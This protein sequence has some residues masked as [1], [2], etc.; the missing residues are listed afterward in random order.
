MTADHE[1]EPVARWLAGLGLH[2]VVLPYPVAPEG[3][4]G[5]L[6]PAPLDAAAAAVRWVRA[7]G[8]GL[9]VDAG[10]VGVL[11]FS[12]GG[13]L[14]AT[15][16]TVEDAGA[17]PDA[18]VLCYPVVSLVAEPHVGSVD[19]LLGTGADADARAALS[20]DRRV[21]AATP[22]A[23]VW[24]TADDDAVPVSHAVRYAQA[25]WAVGVPAEL[26]VYPTGR[27]GLGLA[28]DD[29]HVARWA[30]ACAAWLTQLGWRAPDA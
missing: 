4:T 11:G 27:H 19:A 12:A 30:D 14:A 5:P 7:G 24:H 9:D 1:A 3:A 22:P 23:F 26:H 21:T 6:H 13:H 18:T 10:R 17:R 15:L 16:S 29:V 25:L 20:A 2:A 8:T 28:T